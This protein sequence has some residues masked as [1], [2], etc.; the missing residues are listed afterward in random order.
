MEELD[1]VNGLVQNRSSISLII[2]EDE[3]RF[4]R[5]INI[6]IILNKEKIWFKKIILISPFQKAK[7][8]VVVRWFCPL[9]FL[10]SP[11]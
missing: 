2:K 8:V 6:E 9:A 5:L 4:L 1:V 11:N 10:S 3:V 7:L